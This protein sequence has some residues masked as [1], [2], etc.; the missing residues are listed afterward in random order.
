MRRNVLDFIELT[1]RL[2]LLIFL[3]KSVV[4]LQPIWYIND[5]RLYETRNNVQAPGAS[6]SLDE[7]KHKVIIFTLNPVK[8]LPHDVWQNN[9]MY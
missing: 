7:T 1:F 8:R 4:I 6:S 5:L 9:Q 3:N 2:V